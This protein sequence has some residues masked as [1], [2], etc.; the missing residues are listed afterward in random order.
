M[1]Q[2][3]VVGFFKHSIL[4]LHLGVF[5]QF[6]I[7]PMQ[8]FQLHAALVHELNNETVSDIYPYVFD[9]DLSRR[10]LFGQFHSFGQKE[11]TSCLYYSLFMAH[12]PQI[13]S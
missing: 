2:H 1:L 5:D 11:V 7:I 4:L 6:N 8:W 10:C 9:Y 12:L 3:I 13:F